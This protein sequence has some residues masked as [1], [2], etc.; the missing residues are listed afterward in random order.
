ML[1]LEK[2]ESTEDQYNGIVSNPGLKCYFSTREYRHKTFA[3][4]HYKRLSLSWEKKSKQSNDLVEIKFETE[5]PE[6][7]TL[8]IQESDSEIGTFNQRMPLRQKGESSN[9][10]F[11]AERTRFEVKRIALEATEGSR[12]TFKFN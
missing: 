1:E 11:R 4:K 5:N 6:S 7:T 10:S 9:L 3:N 8:T 2:H 12:Q